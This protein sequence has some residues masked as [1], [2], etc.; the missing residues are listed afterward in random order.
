M[1]LFKLTLNSARKINFLIRTQTFM[2]RKMLT[3]KY[4][5][6]VLTITLQ[7]LTKLLKYI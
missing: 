5:N 2:I 1:I 3:T 6:K 4:L 7:T